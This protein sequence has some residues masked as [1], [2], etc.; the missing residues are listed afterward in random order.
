MHFISQQFAVDNMLRT[1]VAFTEW[2]IRPAQAKSFLGSVYSSS[3]I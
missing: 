1:D 3:S 2:R